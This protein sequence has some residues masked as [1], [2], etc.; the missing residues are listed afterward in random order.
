MGTLLY[1][2]AAQPAELA[3]AF[4]LNVMTGACMHV[5]SKSFRHPRS[6]CPLG[7]M[8]PRWHARRWV[9]E[10]K[11]RDGRIRTLFSPQE[12]CSIA[13]L[14]INLPIKSHQNFLV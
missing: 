6:T 5:N 14:L 7:R 4:V 3:P 13:A 2:G 9:L 10:S 11:V 8:L 12:V 1:G